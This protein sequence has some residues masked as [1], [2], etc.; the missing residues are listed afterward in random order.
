V[1]HAALERHAPGEAN[2]RIGLSSQP[3]GRGLS[4]SGL[5]QYA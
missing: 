3:A 1:A 5:W 2:F 4:G